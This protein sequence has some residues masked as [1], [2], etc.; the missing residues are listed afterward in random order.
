[1]YKQNLQRRL[2]EGIPEIEGKRILL[3]LRQ[4]QN[5]CSHS[6]LAEHPK[7]LLGMKLE[8]TCRNSCI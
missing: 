8:S 5:E 3:P 6:R 1:M 2:L 7:R 4:G